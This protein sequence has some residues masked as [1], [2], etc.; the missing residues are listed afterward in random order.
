MATKKT[1]TKTPKVKTGPLAKGEF[2]LKN[3]LLTIRFWSQSFTTSLFDKNV[4]DFTLICQYP[5]SNFNLDILKDFKAAQ[6][7]IN[8]GGE[9]YIS[10]ISSFLANVSPEAVLLQLTL[11]NLRLKAAWDLEFNTPSVVYEQILSQ[12][13]FFKVSGKRLEDFVK[14]LGLSRKVSETDQA[15]RRRTLDYLHYKMSE[16]GE[17][18]SEADIRKLRGESNG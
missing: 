16:Q 17:T 12:K 8:V 18:I 3:E 7:Y 10:R 1:K 15:L 5:L 2:V 6:L 4:K 11:S 13:E 9:V 14:P